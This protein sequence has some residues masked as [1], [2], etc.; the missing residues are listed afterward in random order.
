MHDGNCDHQITIPVIHLKW[1]QNS[2]SERCIMGTVINRMSRQ[3]TGSSSSCIY[4]C[5]CCSCNCSCSS[6]CSFDAVDHLNFLQLVT[7]TWKVNVL[8][9][10]CVVD[11]S[12]WI[13]L[14]IHHVRKLAVPLRDKLV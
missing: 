6:S 2:C 1:N 12:G 14:H 11:S 3:A 10:V 13:I 9:V 8:A 5:G 4:S 7:K